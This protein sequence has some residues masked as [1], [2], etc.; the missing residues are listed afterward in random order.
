M[1]TFLKSLLGMA[2]RVAVANERIATAQEDIASMLEGV[3]DTL[4][5]RL[6]YTVS[7]IEDKSEVGSKRRS[8]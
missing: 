4:R 1:L 7:V 6:G 5:E 3:R 2:D 8:K